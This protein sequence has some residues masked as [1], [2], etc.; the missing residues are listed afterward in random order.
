MLRGILGA[1]AGIVIGTV[2]IM[3]LEIVGHLVYPFPPGLDPKDHAALSA[4]MMGAPIG[5]WLFVLAAYAAGSFTGGAV[6]T[7]IGR[8]AWIGWAT[9]AV[10]VILG[11]IGLLMTKAPVW[12]WV[13]SLAVYLP[14]AWLGARLARRREPAPAT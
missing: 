1:F 13:A 14:C 5:A 9:G 8:K 7:L 4:Y 12:F 3:L 2:V 6:G 10:F 11:L